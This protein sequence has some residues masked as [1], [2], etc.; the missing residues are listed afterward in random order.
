MAEWRFAVSQPPQAAPRHY[1]L[2][3]DGEPLEVLLL[4]G[5]DGPDGELAVQ[6]DDRSYVIQARHLG[7]GRW[8]LLTQDGQLE[9]DTWL[10]GKGEIGVCLGHH[11]LS[12]QVQDAQRAALRGAQGSL[13]A[14][15]GVARAPM[16]GRVVALLVEVGDEVAPGDGLVV[17]EAMKMENVLSVDVAGTVAALKV[18]IGDPVE[19]GQELVVVE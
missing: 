2:E 13:G 1:L 5:G 4:A 8:R 18:A 3:G 12:W 6:V 7:E 14:G 10:K 9:V 15:R 16:P 11:Q 17:V 19:A